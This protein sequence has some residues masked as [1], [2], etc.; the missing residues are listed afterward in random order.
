MWKWRA[1]Y[2]ASAGLQSAQNNH[3]GLTEEEE[4]STT[5]V[6]VAQP[7]ERMPPMVV[8]DQQPLQA[9]ELRFGAASKV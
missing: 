1:A 9:S 4:F 7:H 6:W 8:E 2:L 5:V 3:E